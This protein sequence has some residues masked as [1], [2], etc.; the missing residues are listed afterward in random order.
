MNRKLM[1]NLL[2]QWIAPMRPTWAIIITLFD[3]NEKGR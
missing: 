2:L 1:E 3:N